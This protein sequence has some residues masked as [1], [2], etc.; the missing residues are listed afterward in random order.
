MKKG[1]SKHDKFLKVSEE[2]VESPNPKATAANFC[3][4]SL[5][6]IRLL[7]ILCT[8]N[9]RANLIPEQGKADIPS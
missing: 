5:R 4:R 7:L 9:R 3:R 2:P 8:I 6:N 1:C